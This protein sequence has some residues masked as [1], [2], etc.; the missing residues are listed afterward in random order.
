MPKRGFGQLIC[1]VVQ[2]LK[3]RWAPMG[4]YFIAI[5]V[6]MTCG[7]MGALRLCLGKYLGGAL[8]LQE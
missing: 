3:H 1:R 5:A 4:K 7:A 2:R 6:E 8:P